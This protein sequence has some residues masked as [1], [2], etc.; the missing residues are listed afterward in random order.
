MASTLLQLRNKVRNK[1]EDWPEQDA[2]NG[3]ISASGSVTGTVDDGSKFHA[4]QYIEIEK[5]FLKM[6]SVA[7]NTLT[8]LRGQKGTTAATHAD[9]S[10]VW[11]NPYWMSSAI[12]DAI[13]E[14]HSKVLQKKVLDDYSLFTNSKVVSHFES[15]ETWTGGTADT[16]KFRTGTQGLRC[17]SSGTAVEPYRTGTF[18]LRGLD[19]DTFDFF[20]YID[21]VDN[22]STLVV[23][24]HTT[25][26][27]ALYSYNVTGLSDGW[28]NVSIK[29]SDFTKTGSADWRQIARIEFEITAVTSTTVNVTLDSLRLRTNQEH[30]YIYDIPTA[31]NNLLEV[32][33]YSNDHKTRFPCRRYRVSDGA[34]T[35]GADQLQFLETVGSG[36]KI[37]LLYK[38]GYAELTADTTETTLPT[39]A[40]LLPVYWACYR[41]LSDKT[42]PRAR[43]DRASVALNEEANP[44]WL[45]RQTADDWLK[46][47]ERERKRV[48]M[49]KG[50]V[51]YKTIENY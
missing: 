25:A 37:G 2:L 10:I 22:L 14:C 4:G 1:L 50:D 36:H 45:A 39:R 49:A 43:Y 40:D 42:A 20:A 11:I 5:E 28:N 26:D 16:A 38:T 29:R 31:C 24:L 35:S 13:N 47:F 27:T 15:T 6:A 51:A 7:T 3:A 32:F 41:M 48:G 8:F 23:K 17:T 18:D 9:D 46:L 33:L 19:T 34:G 21:D 12:D 30:L 44:P